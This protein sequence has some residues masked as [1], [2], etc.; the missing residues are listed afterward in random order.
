MLAIAR[1]WFV[2]TW[3]EFRIEL[4]AS[5]KELTPGGRWVIRFFLPLVVPIYFAAVFV[6]DLIGGPDR[7]GFV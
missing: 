3:V 2:A 1:R 5:M 4:G 6:E 7:G